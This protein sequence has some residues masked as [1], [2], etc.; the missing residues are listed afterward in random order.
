ME[1][2]NENELNRLLRQWEAPPAPS[3]LK[4]RVFP[5]QKKSLWKWL[6]TGSIRIPVPIV[7][8]AALLVI[9]WIHY[10]KAV[11]PPQVVQPGTVSLRDFKPVHQLEPVLVSGGEK[12]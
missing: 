1:P 11:N 8:A 12:K 2:L 10:S 3:T 9:L 4:G 6:C 7:L 5:A